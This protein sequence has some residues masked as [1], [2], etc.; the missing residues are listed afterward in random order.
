V[1]SGNRDER[2]FTLVELLIVISILGLLVAIVAPN[3]GGLLDFGKQAAYNADKATIQI[4]VD[5]YYLTRGRGMYPTDVGGAGSINFT[6]LVTNTALLKTTPQS[7][8]PPQGMGSYTWYV[9]A[10]GIVTSTSVSTAGI[11]CNPG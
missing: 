5:A 7:A 6:C 1:L 9:S 4:A 8:A 11:S 2:G 3:V 10:A